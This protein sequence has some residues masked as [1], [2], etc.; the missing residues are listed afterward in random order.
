[1][2]KLPVIVVALEQRAYNFVLSFFPNT[3]NSAVWDDWVEMFELQSK[4]DI[5]KNQI[6]SLVDFK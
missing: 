6:Y 3:L 1:M 5:E 2:K 4:H